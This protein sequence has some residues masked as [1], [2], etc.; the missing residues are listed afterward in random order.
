ML[1]DMDKEKKLVEKILSWDFD[2]IGLAHKD[3]IESSAKEI[4]RK[5]FLSLIGSA[6]LRSPY[7]DSYYFLVPGSVIDHGSRSSFSLSAG[8]TFCSRA[9]SLTVLPVA[10]ASLAILA[11]LS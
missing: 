8:R 10:Y 4:V 7:L 1:K 3:I 5:A 9:T 11:A 2:R 6:F